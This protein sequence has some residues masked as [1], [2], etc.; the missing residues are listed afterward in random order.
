MI[1]NINMIKKS[2]VF[3]LNNQLEVYELDYVKESIELLALEKSEKRL[4]LFETFEG[5][6]LEIWEKI[7]KTSEIYFV[8]GDQAGFTNTR[9][10]YLWLKSLSEFGLSI[11]LKIVKNSNFVDLQNQ[12]FSLIKSILQSA[13]KQDL[14][15]SQEPR[16]GQKIN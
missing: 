2:I 6:W 5:V 10:V 16:I 4:Q 9:I 3:Y 14:L 7:K 11:E 1:T 15:Y 8:L 13:T 12:P